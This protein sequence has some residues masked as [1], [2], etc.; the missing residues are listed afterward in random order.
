MSPGR[1]NGTCH[2]NDDEWVEYRERADRME[3]VVM[4]IKGQ[5]ANLVEYCSHLK[6]LDALDDI[7]DHLMSAATGGNQLDLGMKIAKLLSWIFG[8]IIAVLLFVICFLLTGQS[9]G[10][11][12]LASPLTVAHTQEK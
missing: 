1:L 3:Q 7:K 9:V 6:K 12:K 2:L 8:S 5:N 10:W 11:I 4:E